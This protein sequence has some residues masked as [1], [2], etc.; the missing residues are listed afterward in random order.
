MSI[1]QQFF[2]DAASLGAASSVYLDNSLSVCAPDGY[3][4]DGVITRQQV[5]CSLLP[6]EICP[7]CGLPCNSILTS[8]EATHGVF[9]IESNMG[10]TAGAILLWFNPQDVPE[11]IRV[12]F[13][14]QTDNKFSSPIY[15]KLQSSNPYGYT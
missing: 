8:D 3:Y 12:V 5:S 11:G 10:T 15:G 6:E 7:E 9:R 14:S 2:L 1:S 13:N 4:S